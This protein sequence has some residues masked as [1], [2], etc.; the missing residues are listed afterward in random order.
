VI[1]A[2]QS[3]L[4]DVVVP[5]V[6]IVLDELVLAVVAADVALLTEVMIEAPVQK[7]MGRLEAPAHFRVRVSQAI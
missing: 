1:N 2:L 7:A 4:E 3:M 6:V 5:V